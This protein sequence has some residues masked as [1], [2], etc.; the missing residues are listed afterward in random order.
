MITVPVMLVIA[1][2][3][4]SLSSAIIVCKLMNLPDPRT[5]GSNNPG[6]TNV[7][8]V[9]GKLPAAITLLGDFFKGNIPVFIAAILGVQG[10]FLGLIAI[11]AMLGH[12]FPIFFKFQGGKGVA[13]FF[14]SLIALNFF[15]GG[16]AIA[17]WLVVVAIT[18]Y[19]S[20]ASLTSA[21]LALLYTLLFGHA[22]YFIPIFIMAAIMIW[23]HW[24]NIQR[25]KSGTENKFNF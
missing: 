17:T 4:G 16:V 11:A 22:E 14:G 18:R 10:F 2:L 9:G 8:R 25:L 12:I 23:S 21:I 1:Y 3:I 20:V 5:Q 19:V 7:L 24:E 15:V 6:A 13:T